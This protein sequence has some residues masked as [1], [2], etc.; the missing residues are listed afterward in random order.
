[1]L[2][3]IIQ[4]VDVD[5]VQSPTD[6]CAELKTQV[7]EKK[8]NLW[9]Q[10][11]G[12]VNERRLKTA[13]SKNLINGVDCAN[14]DK[15]PFCEACVQGKQARKPFKGLADVQTKYKLELVHS[16]VCGLCLLYTS[17]SPRD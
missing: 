6:V 12:H 9:H 15:L 11:L 8:L 2:L 5:T 14:G 16:D 10:R 17:P 1:M 3:I 4:Y 7:K 13:V